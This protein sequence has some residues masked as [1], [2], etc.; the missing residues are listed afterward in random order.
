MPPRTDR[1]GELAPWIELGLV[2]GLGPANYRALLAAFGLPEQVLG[3]T[4]AQLS[5]VVPNA[6][7]KAILSQKRD[8]DVA[9]TLDWLGNPRNHILTLADAEYPKQLFDI[10]DPL[11]CCMCAGIQDTCR[12]RPSAL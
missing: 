3:A 7:A 12:H 4:H 5:S 8:D 2:T 6:I 11:P 10:P 9:R 1:D